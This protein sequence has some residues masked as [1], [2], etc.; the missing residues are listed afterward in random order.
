[1]SGRSWVVLPCWWRGREDV[2]RK[3]DRGRGEGRELLANPRAVVCLRPSPAP[4]SASTTATRPPMASTTDD[5]FA[6]FVDR[7]VPAA[8]PPLLPVLTPSLRLQDPLQRAIRSR[9]QL[10]VQACHPPQGTAQ[11][12]S[13]LPPT[14]SRFGYRLVE[15]R[16]SA[17]RLVGPDWESV[18]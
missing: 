11:A 4:D 13:V 12:G 5:S 8:L 6:Q 15:T 10:R 3:E 17:W 14:V 2:R 7:S 16:P 1:M 18:S 9:R